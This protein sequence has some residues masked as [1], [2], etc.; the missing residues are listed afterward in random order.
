[1]GRD[2]G[3]VLVALGVL[4]VLVGVLAWAGGLSWFGHLPGD[5]RLER[6]GLNLYVPI[7]SMLLVSLVV[8]LLLWFIR[9]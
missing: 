4:L 6:P 5:L 3:P 1:M 7:T 2:L 9:R 8:S